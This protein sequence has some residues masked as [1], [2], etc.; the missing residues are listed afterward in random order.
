MDWKGFEWISHDD[1]RNNIVAFR[2][3]AQNGSDLVFVVN[4]APVEHESYRIG[5]PYKGSYTEVF[6]SNLV[7][8]GGTGLANG[9]VTSQKA[10]DVLEPVLDEEENEIAPTLHGFENLIDI[11]I[12]PLSMLCFKGRKSTAGKR[13]TVKVSKAKAK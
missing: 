4:F 12:P 1:N 5:V 6:N 13:K 3:I 11:K 7:E 10:A 2:R 9:K 8:F